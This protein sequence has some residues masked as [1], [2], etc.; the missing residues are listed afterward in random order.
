ML[1]MLSLAHISIIYF[2]YEEK[3]LCFVNYISVL[4]DA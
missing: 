4:Y 1:L 2:A 3:G